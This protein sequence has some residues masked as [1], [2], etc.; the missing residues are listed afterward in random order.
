MEIESGSPSM[1]LPPGFPAR[2]E[3]RM[4][5][6]GSD[7]RDKNEY[8]YKLTPADLEEINSALQEFKKL[9]LD[10]DLVDAENFPLRN[11]KHMFQNLCEELHEGRGFFV[12][13][14]LGSQTYCVEDLTVIYLGIQSYIA[15]KRGR[16]TEAGDMI[17]H[18]INDSKEASKS[19]TKR[20]SDH[21]I[22]F[23]TDDIGDIVAY[24]DRAALKNGSKGVVSSAISVYNILAAERPDVI[25]TLAK[26]DWPFFFPFY[27]K[28]PILFHHNSKL[29]INFAIESIIGSAE[30]PRPAEIPKC[31]PQQLEALTVLQNAAQSVA[32]QFETE[33]G[34]LRFIN[35]LAI[36]HRRD[37]YI[38]EDESTERGH[39]ARLCLRNDQRRWALPDVFVKDW[40][41]VFDDGNL[42]ER[43]W[44]IDPMPE[45]FFPMRQYGTG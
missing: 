17:V 45:A 31:T 21:S 1:E 37:V 6:S 27:Q 32:L 35:N 30:H 19:G 10:G 2:V 8:V 23:H 18:I 13:R 11:L 3:T 26:P 9:G 39:L 36:L 40:D 34:D 16:Q 43:V 5:W 41:E 25:H 38:F 42:I 33:V 28:R 29:I 7:L 44:N 14:G 24:Q 22:S 15:N 12:I 20:P 4:A